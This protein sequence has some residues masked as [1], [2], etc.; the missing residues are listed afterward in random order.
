MTDVALLERPLY[1]VAEAARL[2]GLRPDKIRRWLDGYTRA[3]VVYE[4]VIRTEPTGSEVVTWGEF[5]ELGYLREFRHA[6][7]SLQRLRPFVVALREEFGI[8]Y[9]LAHEG[10]FLGGRRDLVLRLQL[11]SEV[12]E[13][14]YMVVDPAQ[15]GQLVIPQPALTEPAGRFL[16]RV[17]FEGHVARQWRPYGPGSR[18]I[19]DPAQTFGIPTI[20][21]IRTEVLLEAFEAGEAIDDLADGFDLSR[22]DVEEA[23]RWER[24]EHQEAAA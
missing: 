23:I 3:G 7:V 5:I 11:E 15:T 18:V 20:K 17:N 14:L 6:K 13:A 4:P 8:P 12:P 16:Q 21:G 22:E 2:L 10:T 24:R 19:V 1:E 9:P